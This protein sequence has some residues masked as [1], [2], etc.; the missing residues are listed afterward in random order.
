MSNTPDKRTRDILKEYFETGD[1]PKEIEFIRLIDSGINQKD[2]ELY[3]VNGNIGVGTSNPQSKLHVEG[4]IAVTNHIHGD[5]TN[6][7]ND[8][9]VLIVEN[10][11][12]V[13]LHGPRHT[14]KSGGIVIGAKKDNSN[15]TSGKIL[16]SQV[17]QTGWQDNV[18]IDHQGNVGIG[19]INP[20]SKLHVSG[21]TF[22]SKPGGANVPRTGN[23]LEV[24]AHNQNAVAIVTKSNDVLNFVDDGATINPNPFT[25][26]D[27]SGRG[28]RFYKNAGDVATDGEKLRIQP[29]GHVGIG[30]IDP[31]SKLHI[32]QNGGNT[33]GLRL[34]G[35]DNVNPGDILTLDQDGNAKWAAP[36]SVTSGLWQAIGTT[37]HIENGNTGNVGVGTSNPQATLDI[38]GTS[39]N[40]N[41]HGILKISAGTVGKDLRFGV[42]DGNSGYTWI[43]SHGAI[44]LKIN[45][46]PAGNTTTINEGGGKV[47]I[48]T[49]D[50]KERL[51]VWGNLQ[52]QG[53][54]IGKES[55]GML[56]IFSAKMNGGAYMH[57]NSSLLMDS[58]NP[59][60]PHSNQGGITFVATAGSGNKNG[61]TFMQN[62]PG[63]SNPWPTCMSIEGNRNSY[64]WNNKIYFRGKWDQ[65]HGLAH[66]GDT[67]D[68]FA[69]VDVNGPALFGFAGG[70][71]GSNQYGTENIA[72]RWDQYQRVGINGLGDN[73]H[74]PFKLQVWGDNNVPLMLETKTNDI[75]HFYDND[76]A[77]DPQKVRAK[78]PFTFVDKVGRGFRFWNAD[79][80]GETLTVNGNGSV[81][82][83]GNTPFIIKRYP[84]KKETY[85]RT[86]TEYS[87]DYYEA[88]VGSFLFGK[89]TSTAVLGAVYVDE[90]CIARI[91]ESGGNFVLEA[92]FP[93]GTVNGD[94]GGKG[95]EKM[96]EVLFIRKEFAFRAPDASKV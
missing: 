36:T 86:I 85:L 12:Q 91:Y 60:Q 64:F 20:Q 13:Q 17:S 72:L 1:R 87:P 30:T 95:K 77:Q 93:N 47:G 56:N 63:S 66:F 5:K 50:P 24:N 11:S 6:K 48:G 41:N 40:E 21:Q 78:A 70:A 89:M 53:D 15:P 31:K 62:N 96:V 61:F 42:M 9:D 55:G 68:K 69:G 79:G 46:H 7:A 59:S 27:N 3:A 10:G 34:S 67:N 73:T 23:M 44:P 25:I 92:R 74:W 88:I 8:S 2:D 84:F 54:I 57:L 45:P 58:N 33:T 4:D 82:I 75:I 16:F 19:A 26:T 65:N 35:Q 49:G 94:N 18:V 90:Y 76:F 39:E 37:G 38:S 43:Q 32:H 71:L 80:I 28:F 22:V 52:V 83:R 51:H 14:G 81:K 29:N